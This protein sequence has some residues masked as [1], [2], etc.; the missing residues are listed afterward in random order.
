MDDFEKENPEKPHGSMHYMP[1]TEEMN[2]ACVDMSGDSF[3]SV[4]WHT[5]DNDFST[6]IGFPEYNEDRYEYYYKGIGED[7]ILNRIKGIKKRYMNFFDYQNALDTYNEY[8]EYLYDI[9]GSKKILKKMIKLELVTEDIP[10]KPTLKNTKA[11]RDYIKY[12]IMPSQRMG[13][14][15]PYDNDEFRADIERQFPVTQEDLDEMERLADPL[16]ELTKE[17]RKYYKREAKFAKA[18]A[19]NLSGTRRRKSIFSR[20]RVRNSGDMIAELFTMLGDPDRPNAPYVPKEMSRQSLWEIYADDRWEHPDEYYDAG[21]MTDEEYQ[22]IDN[23]KNDMFVE[24]VNGRLVKSR[25]ARYLKVLEDMI[26]EGFNM[27][28]YMPSVK[29]YR[30]LG[31]LN[32]S[33]G[34]DGL[35]RKEKAR[36]RKK[37]KKDRE[38]LER[39]ARE[40]RD[41]MNILTRH[42]NS[43][44][45]KKLKALT[46]DDGSLDLFKGFPTF[47]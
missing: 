37:H 20:N 8:M 5:L 10:K 42:C 11:N 1:T 9:Y 36:W 29:R 15:D 22:E 6:D 4:I 26:S 39:S 3:G 30:L 7:S 35:S 28:A 34:I 23:E 46:N 38:K 14:E 24:N 18:A 12:G 40:D 13:D 47:D 17:E 33:Q 27:D 44:T 21:E 32:V 43:S 16:R 2:A 45:K 25:D 41:I 31:K 19:A